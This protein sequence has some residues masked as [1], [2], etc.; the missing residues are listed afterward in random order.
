MEHGKFC[1]FNQAHSRE[2]TIVHSCLLRIGI[3]VRSRPIRNGQNRKRSIQCGIPMAKRNEGK[4]NILIVTM[5]R[6]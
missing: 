4:T 3:R 6:T 1:A 2:L 5:A